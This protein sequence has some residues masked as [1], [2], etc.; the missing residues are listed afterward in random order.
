MKTSLG[1]TCS[2]RVLWGALEGGAGGTIAVRG[3]HPVALQGHAGCHEGVG[4]T[5]RERGVPHLV[6]RGSPGSRELEI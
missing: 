1:L 5:N 2:L 4:D 3:G 6:L